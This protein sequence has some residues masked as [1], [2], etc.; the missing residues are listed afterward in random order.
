[1]ETDPSAS[2]REHETVTGQLPF[3]VLDPTRQ[4]QLTVPDALAVFGPRP[5]AVEGPDL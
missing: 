1:L 3:E 4:D 2:S 5:E